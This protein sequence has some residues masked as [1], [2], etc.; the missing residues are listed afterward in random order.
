MILLKLKKGNSLNLFALLLIWPSFLFVSSTLGKQAA[1]FLL[2]SYGSI[3]LLK[4]DIKKL[5]STS[6]FILI[7]LVYIVAINIYNWTGI[8]DAGDII[9]TLGILVFY[10]LGRVGM[11]MSKRNINYY[12]TFLFFL[13]SSFLIL[14]DLIDLNFW[15]YSDFGRRFFGTMNSPNYYW[16]IPIALIINLKINQDKLNNFQIAILFCSIIL[17]GSRTVYILFVIYV[18][19]KNFNF[20]KFIYLFI[21]IGFI[22]LIFTSFKDQLLQFFAIKRIYLLIQALSTLDLSQI[23]SFNNRLNIWGT[24]DL[25]NNFLGQGSSKLTGSNSIF[26]NSYITTLIRY[27]LLGI[28]IEFLILISLSFHIIKTRSNVK[29]EFFALLILYLVSCITTSTLYNLKLPYIFF[30]LFGYLKTFNQDNVR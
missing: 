11:L 7:Y 24:L 3:L 21:F 15:V 26:D 8:R 27:G 4:N 5:D 25:N 12:I 29:I 10:Q 16:I 17:T 20:K 6:F 13:I 14:P 28:I 23:E 1:A 2:I 18:I 9:R 30:Y 22:S 19:I